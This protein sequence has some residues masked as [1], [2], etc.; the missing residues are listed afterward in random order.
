MVLRLD[1]SREINKEFYG[2]GRTNPK[3][4]IPRLVSENRVIMNGAYLMQR[5]LEY[6]DGPAALKSAWMNYDFMLGDVALCHPAG[7]I[8]IVLDCDILRGLNPKSEL[9]SDG[10]I[11]T[12]ALVLPDGM[13]EKIQGDE[14]TRGEIKGWVNRYLSSKEAK[15]NPVLRLLA[16]D[17]RLLN[18]YVDYIFA[19]NEKLPHPFEKMIGVD[20][21]PQKKVPTLHAFCVGNISAASSFSAHSNFNSEVH[22]L[23]GVAKE[24]LDKDGNIA[25]VQP[26]TMKDVERARQ[27]LRALTQVR[28]ELL[29]KTRSLVAR[30]G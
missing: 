13:Y 23:V 21:A 19:E 9:V 1:S 15:K 10:S 2:N 24:A 18:E 26:Y 3:N 14:F 17:P 30:L 4:L 20:F 5:R 27:E 29:K 28:P 12:G 7:K 6:R 22:R 8:K 16:R 11:D 25:T